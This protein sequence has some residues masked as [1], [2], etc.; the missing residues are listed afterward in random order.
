MSETLATSVSGFEGSHVERGWCFVFRSAMQVRQFQ[1]SVPSLKA[2]CFGDAEKK[3]LLDLYRLRLQFWAC[4]KQSLLITQNNE[5]LRLF[6]TYHDKSQTELTFLLNRQKCCENCL[7][8]ALAVPGNK[9]AQ[10]RRT[11]VRSGHTLSTWETAH[12]TRER[13]S[14]KKDLIRAYLNDL[15]EVRHQKFTN[16]LFDRFFCGHE[17]QLVVVCYFRHRKSLE[18]FSSKKKI[19]KIFFFEEKKFKIFLF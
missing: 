6:N 16:S 19:L 12:S 15:K 17:N 18:F 11:W 14:I 5:L 7:M 2:C 3:D 4:D 10:V 13:K 1:I 9:Y 8:E